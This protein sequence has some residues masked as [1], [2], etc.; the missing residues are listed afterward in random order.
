MEA[1]NAFAL[2]PLS[3]GDIIDRAVRL[4]RRHFLVL[5]RIVIGPSLVAYAG[6]IMYT[7]GVRNFSL[8]RGDGRM[9]FMTG[10]VLA[11]MICY[12]V[13]K[14]AFFAMLGGTARSLAAYFAVGEPLRARDVFRTVRARAWQLVGATIVVF[15]LLLAVVSFLYMFVV[16]GLILYVVLTAWVLAGAPAWLMG[17]VH[18]S[19]GLAIAAALLFVFLI[20]YSRIVFVPQALMVEEKG[21]FAAIFRSIALAGR[22]VR[23]IAAILAFQIYIA[24]SLMLLLV[25]PLGWYGYLQGVDVN[26]I[27]GAAPLWYNIAQQ[28]LAQ[29]SEIL[30]API[31][32][33]SFTLLYL[34]VR[35]R[36]EGLDVELLAERR[37]PPVPLVVWTPP[38]EHFDFIPIEADRAGFD[39]PGLIRLN[40][41]SD[42]PPQ[43]PVQ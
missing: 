28:T 26:P 38:V 3:A 27:S 4:Y 17:V 9:I 19:A 24:W 33:L 13:G 11:G 6:G 20:V 8:D 7:I 41:D 22:D 37:L 23:K 5:L 43:P 40:L 29:A 16:F 30:L 32:M 1:F 31:A 2:E 10:L 15:V 35:V 42:A 39:A 18:V 34:D 25:I 21:V 36:R 14:I 12:V